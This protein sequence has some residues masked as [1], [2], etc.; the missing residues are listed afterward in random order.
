MRTVII[1]ILLALC[2]LVVPAVSWQSVRGPSRPHRLP[3]LRRPAPRPAL[4]AIAV[5]LALSPLR[6]R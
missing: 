5:A 6:R 2:L 1:L 4:R 3:L